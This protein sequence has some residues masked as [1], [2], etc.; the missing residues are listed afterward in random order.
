MVLSCLYSTLVAHWLLSLL[1]LKCSR[2]AA[3]GETQWGCREPKMPTDG[4]KVFSRSE[5][6]CH[7]QCWMLERYSWRVEDAS[8]PCKQRVHSRILLKINQLLLR[9]FHYL[10]HGK[11]SNLYLVLFW[12]LLVWPVH[13][14]SFVTVPRMDA[15]VDGWSESKGNA[16]ITLVQGAGVGGGVGL[17]CKILRSSW[18]AFWSAFDPV[19]CHSNYSLNMQQLQPPPQIAVVQN[20]LKSWTIDCCIQLF[21]NLNLCCGFTAQASRAWI[22]PTG[23][24]QSQDFLSFDFKEIRAMNTQRMYILYTNS[25]A[26]AKRLKSSQTQ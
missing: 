26:E 12:Y 21:T 13:S 16:A 2:L 10:S 9:V 1:S 3:L 6:I 23:P 14:S 19:I 5:V 8:M 4:L 17:L 20:C 11:G 15:C 25:S 22:K 7:D 24:R 18:E